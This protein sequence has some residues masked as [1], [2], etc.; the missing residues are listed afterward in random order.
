[1]MVARRVFARGCIREGVNMN[2]EAARWFLAPMADL[3]VFLEQT[4][5]VS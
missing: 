2:L 1:M 4:D 3:T 5:K